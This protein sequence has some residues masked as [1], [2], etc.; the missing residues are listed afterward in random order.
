MNYQFVL[1]VKK[2]VFLLWL[3]P[4]TVL[5]Q[6]L[7]MIVT[8]GQSFDLRISCRKKY[9]FVEVTRKNVNKLCHSSYYDTTNEDD[10]AYTYYAFD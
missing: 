4:K 7:S 1:Q 2:M 9:F 5:N 3:K 10:Y 8:Q 6:N